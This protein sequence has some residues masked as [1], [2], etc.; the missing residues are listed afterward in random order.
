MRKKADIKDNEK[1]IGIRLVLMTNSS[2][3]SNG[4]LWL[5]VTP[6][7]KHYFFKEDKHI[8]IEAIN[9]KW[10]ICSEKS[11]FL[12]SNDG[13]NKIVELKD[14]SLIQLKWGDISGAIYA[15]YLKPRNQV[16][17]NYIIKKD[18]ISIGRLT[19]N[20]IIYNNTFVSRE[21]AVI[22][23]TGKGLHLI[24][25]NSTNHVNVNGH[26]VSDI[27]LEVGDV[28]FL[29]GLKIIVGIDFLSINSGH[30][31]VSVNVESLRQIQNEMFSYSNDS[32]S[33]RRR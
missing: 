10:Y 17:Y 29:F 7:G 13:E 23:R 11:I 8:Y 28:I 21:H 9:N 15:E 16:F 22:M 20:D 1:F 31:N 33:E 6:Q 25:K 24:D 2:A 12:N 18:T 19:Q 3:A 30:E 14:N 5:P 27:D 26:F 4:S 32:K